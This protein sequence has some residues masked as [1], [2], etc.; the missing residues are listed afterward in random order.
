MALRR[1]PR[2]AA[3][4]GLR[5]RLQL[6]RAARRP[7][8]TRA[9]RFTACAPEAFTSISRRCDEEETA[10]V[11]A[12]LIRFD[13]VN[14]PG[15]ERECLEWL[16][17]LPAEAGLEVEL[18]GAEPER[19][20]L[21]AR[22]KGGR[23]GPVLGYLGHVDTVLADPDDWTPTPGRATSPTAT[24]GARRAGHEGPDR[25]RGRRRRERSPAA[26]GGRR[27]AS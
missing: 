2:L 8:T 12:R 10:D 19:P 13:T 24:C 6:D 1:S 9:A 7:S 15:N 22:L 27:G 17:G 14:P 25:G 4:D 21:V 20:N 5:G 23:A 18:L 26:A 3:G 11:L 16:A